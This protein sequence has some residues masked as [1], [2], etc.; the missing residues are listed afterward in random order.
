MTL[1]Y[2]NSIKVFLKA[3]EKA[4]LPQRAESKENKNP[5]LRCTV[6][7]VRSGEGGR[8]PLTIPHVSII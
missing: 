4:G 2:R 7:S 3:K 1:P 6:P 5:G 8:C